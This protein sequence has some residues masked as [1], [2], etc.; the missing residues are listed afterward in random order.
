MLPFFL[1]MANLEM[2]V[3]NTFKCEAENSCY[4]ILCLSVLLHAYACHIQ[5]D[6]SELFANYEKIKL[7][8]YT[9]EMVNESNLS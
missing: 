7:D 8:H 4:K 9:I 2:N 3:L 5:R 1:N 6:F